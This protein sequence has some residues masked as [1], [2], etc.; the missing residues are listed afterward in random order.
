MKLKETD[1]KKPFCMMLTAVSVFSLASCVNEEYDLN[2]GIDMTINIDGDI[3]APLGST[4]AIMIGDFLDIDEENSVLLADETGDYSLHVEAEEPVG[5]NVII[6]SVSIEDYESLFGNGGFSLDVDVKHYVDAAEEIIGD[7]TPVEGIIVTDVDILNGT[8]QTTD[9]IIR[10]DVSQITD[11]VKALGTIAL[12]APLVLTL[13]ISEGE[14][15][16][17]G[18]LKLTFPACVGLSLSESYDFCSI[19]EGHILEFTSDVPVKSDSPVTI[20]LQM[21]SIDFTALQGTQQGLVGTD[22]IVEQT[23]ELSHFLI[24]AEAS[25]FGSTFGDMPTDLQISLD[26]RA[27]RMGVTG[28]TAV[29]DPSVEVEDGTVSVGELPEFLTGENVVLDIYNPV[30]RLDVKNSSPAS[31]LLSAKIQGYDADGN[32]IGTSITIGSSDKDAPDAIFMQPGS[33]SFY[34]SAREIELDIE[35]VYPLGENPPCNVVVPDLP[36]IV[37]TIPYS[38]GFSDISIVVPHEGSAEDGYEESDYVMVVF[39]EDGSDLEY[40]FSADYTIDVP[41]SFGEDLHIEYPYDITGLNETLSPDD[42]GTTIRLRQAQIKL[43]F[44]NTIP[45]DMGVTASPIDVDGN[46]ISDQS[47]KVELLSADGGEAK[48]SAGALGNETSCPSVI[49]VEADAETLKKLDGFRLNITGEANEEY[50]GNAL[51]ANQYI[52]IIDMSVRI[53]GGVDMQL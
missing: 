33:T 27:L 5:G 1:L 10:Q 44:I 32:G 16:V 9:V 15:T 46:V 52:R 2:K 28:G 6:P 7:E 25:D 48:I 24:D 53:N 51:N 3:S 8:R 41:L 39:P 11:V 47:L 20:A 13:G 40:S 18:G 26:M 42:N 43:T 45:L 22:I 4:E 17:N 31:A 37:R 12:D 14:V 36:D 35:D 19:N 21:T 50:V 30:I 23:I 38:V 29:I 49:N 34:I